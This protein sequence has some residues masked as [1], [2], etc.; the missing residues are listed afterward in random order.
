MDSAGT[1]FA[2]FGL[3]TKEEDM[4]IYAHMRMAAVSMA[5]IMLAVGITET[6]AAADD[7]MTMGCR[8]HF[9]LWKKMANHKAFAV[10]Q[11]RSGLQ[12]CGY[13][14]AWQTREQA[15][16]SAMRECAKDSQRY[17]GTE[18]PICRLVKVN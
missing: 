15:I 12:G 14:W 11:V 3:N 7:G 10:S 13:S 18:K 4:R 1:S 5:A 17:L 9:R 6:A 8:H 2:C 16:S